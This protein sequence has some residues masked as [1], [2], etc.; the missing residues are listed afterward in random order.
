[1]KQIDLKTNDDDER[2]KLNGLYLRL[3][4][5]GFRWLY[6]IDAI[7]IFLIMVLVNLIRFGTQWPEKAEMWIGVIAA[8]FIFQIIFYFGGL[9]EKQVRL[10]Q[11]MWFSQVAAMTLIGLLI[12][13]AFTLPTGRYPIPRANLPVVG[14]LIA[15]AA[16]GSRE[17]SRKLRTRRFGPPKVILVGSHQQTELATEHLNESDRGAVV[18]AKLNEEIEL[19][20]ELVSEVE[21]HNATDVVFVD[22]IPLE[23]IFPEPAKTLDKKNVGS[24]LRVTA[25]TALIGLREVR[26]ISGMPYVA[27]R[28]KSLRPHQMRLK[29]LIELIVVLIFSPLVLTSF[30][31]I[32]LLLKIRAKKEI[33]IKQERIGKDGEIFTLF[34]FRTMKIDA[35][36]DGKAKLAQIDDERILKGCNW[37][38]RTRLDEVPQFW[39][40]LLGQMSIVGPRPERPEMVSKFASEIIGYTRR[41]EIPPGITGLAQTRSGY[42]TD[43]SY[44]LG[45]DLQYLMSWSPVLD[46]QIMLKTIVV[47]FR[48]K[49]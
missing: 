39:N 28:S 48:R 20:S 3:W 6:I 29:R 26:E 38:R 9:Y 13:G 34:K 45:H 31:F 10:G 19:S 37:L 32:A 23:K 22:D 33:I 8:T 40:V 4:H 11:R 18:V 47:M 16:S 1:M 15:L 27:L 35:E 7:A 49:Q 24:Y 17:L 2:F 42:H 12:I 21:K 41:H 36:I 30:L 25:A 44:K 43:A 14:V 46:L 5:A